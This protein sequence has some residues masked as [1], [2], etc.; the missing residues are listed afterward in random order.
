MPKTIVQLSDDWTARVI[1]EGQANAEL[2]KTPVTD[3]FFSRTEDT[4]QT[5]INLYDFVI[6]NSLGTHAAHNGDSRP[7]KDGESLQ[8]YF[9]LP[10]FHHHKPFSPK[11]TRWQNRK[12]EWALDTALRHDS[13]DR[14]TKEFMAT[15]ALIEGGIV[16]PRYPSN[17]LQIMD[18][19]T[20][21]VVNAFNPNFWSMINTL[22]AE[23]DKIRS[24]GET[25]Y[26]ILEANTITK[27]RDAM[28]L[29]ATVAPLSLP[30]VLKGIGVVMIDITA[31]FEDPD[32]RVQ[33]GYLAPYQAFLANPRPMQCKMV[34]GGLVNYGNPISM[35]QSRLVTYTETTT[36]ELR[37]SFATC[38]APVLL[39]LDKGQTLLDFA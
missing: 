16:D 27:L 17:P 25:V 6:D 31:G 15:M 12:E 30:D 36:T 33:I 20:K 4:I 39:G 2:V 8:K 23:A 11:N 22:S 10:L 14:R 18:I 5:T 26:L 19:N 32:S 1:A 34:Y 38:R 28:N 35:V 13:M 3:A 9:E 21:P 24:T 37:L 7:M 29:V